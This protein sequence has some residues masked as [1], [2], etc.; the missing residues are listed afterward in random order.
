MK[1]LALAVGCAAL[2]VIAIDADGWTQEPFPT[3]PV[4]VIVPATAGGPVDTA[5][6][7][8]APELETALGQPVV[9]LNRPGASGTLG[10][11]DV[12][13]AVSD[14][15]T[16]GQGVNSIFTITRISG[17]TVPF[18]LDD[19]SLLGNYAT[20]VSV[21]AVSADAPWRTLDD[22]ID[23]VHNNPG[24]LNYASAGVGTVSSL[25]MQALAHHFKLTMVAVP[26]QGGAQLTTAILGRQVDIGMVPYTTGAAMFA[27]G[28]LRALVTTAPQRLSKL[29]A[30]PTLAE[31]GIAVN[32]LNLIMG[33]YAPR[34]L[35]DVVRSTLVDAVA[36][37]AKD[38]A[39]VAKIEAIGLFGQYED[40]AT[41]RSRL[42]SEYADIVALN[43][44]LQN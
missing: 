38:P 19:F 28:K 12:A 18:T 39:F 35:S 16:I 33:L 13:T 17:T 29:P 32:G 27:A 31:K 6:R 37:A 21:L 44:A 26:F 30:V 25:S 5:V 40:P 9:L 11:H 42:E 15:Y 22:I 43:R 3:R 41:A 20:D 36:K 14:G 24:K 7:M 34:G 4:Q 2:A 23:Y 10:M 1:Q 8:I